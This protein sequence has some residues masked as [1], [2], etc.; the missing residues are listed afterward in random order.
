MTLHTV[1]DAPRAAAAVFAAMVAASASTSFAQA[2]AKEGEIPSVTV[3]YGDLNLATEAGSRALYERLVVAAREVCPQEG[4]TLL[5]L[6]QNLEA[7]RCID[8]AVER[9]V[10]EVHNPKFAEIATSRMR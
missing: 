2:S 7:Q 8:G 3:E 1:L 9:A 6:R 10:K 4:G 5:A